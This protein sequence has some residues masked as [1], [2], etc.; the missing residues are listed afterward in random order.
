LEQ[1]TFWHANE[2]TK[3]GTSISRLICCSKSYITYVRVCASVMCLSS[4]K[5]TAYATLQILKAQRN[6]SMFGRKCRDRGAILKGRIASNSFQLF[7]IQIPRAG[8]VLFIIPPL[9]KAIHNITN[10]PASDRKS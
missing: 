8:G 10:S 1:H 2:T 5:G 9:P 3:E 6:G 4:G 7:L